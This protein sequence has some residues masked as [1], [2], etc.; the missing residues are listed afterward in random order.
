M[1]LGESF[2]IVSEKLVSV[3]CSSEVDVSDGFCILISALKEY[4]LPGIVLIYCGSS[5]ESPSTFLRLWIC[6]KRLFGSR[7]TPDQ[8]FSVNSCL[9]TILLL[10]SIK[11][12][13]IS[14]CL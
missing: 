11:Q 6:T 1:N 5:G 12:I 10:R 14:N 8:T 9:V 13:R 3:S 2:L 4:P 7:W